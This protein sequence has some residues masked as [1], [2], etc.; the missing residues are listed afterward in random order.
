MTPSS[1]QTIKTI[2]E[3]AD[4][5]PVMIGRY[6]FIS[7]IKQFKY[8]TGQQVSA[9]LIC[10]KLPCKENWCVLKCCITSEERNSLGQFSKVSFSYSMN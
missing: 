5:Q 6:T 3:Q 9:K 8:G 2:L 10:R 4:M 1:P 7:A